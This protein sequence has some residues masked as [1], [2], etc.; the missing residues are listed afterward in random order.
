[1]TVR[2]NSDK[3]LLS[4]VHQMGV[5]TMPRLSDT[6]YVAALRRD[7]WSSSAS[8]SGSTADVATPDRACPTGS[9][10]L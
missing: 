8:V 6:R 7:A 2:Y 9:E 4:Y 5:K 1:M 3:A 10:C